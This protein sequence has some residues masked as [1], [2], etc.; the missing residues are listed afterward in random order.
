[1]RI[2]PTLLEILGAAVRADLLRSRLAARGNRELG[3]RIAAG[4]HGSL[5][6]PTLTGTCG[7]SPRARPPR[8]SRS[9]RGRLPTFRSSSSFPSP[10]RKQA[11]DEA[12]ICRELGLRSVLWSIDSGDTMPFST[13]RIVHE[14]VGRVHPGDIVLMHDGG[15]R[16]QRTLDGTRRILDEL[17]AAG[18]E[19]VTVSRASSW[20]REVRREQQI[21][22]R[23]RCHAGLQR[24]GVHPPSASKA[25]SRRPNVNW[26][27]T[28]IDNASTDATPEIIKQ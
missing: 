28:I 15:D 10:V 13:D 18:Y 7:S 6:T 14:V 5:T 8:R 3:L 26:D 27:Y 12:R 2:P 9:V 25:S 21:A 24:R 20:P 1:M 23:Q 17:A 19:F 22:A 11:R 4:G 16:R